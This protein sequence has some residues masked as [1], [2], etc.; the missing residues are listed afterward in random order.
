[1]LHIGEDFSKEYQLPSKAI[2]WSKQPVAGRDGTPEA[3]GYLYP[4][5]MVVQWLG[6]HLERQPYA[7]SQ[8]IVMLIPLAFSFLILI[9]TAILTPPDRDDVTERFFLKMRTKVR[10][11]GPEED[12][13][14]LE[15]AFR[16]PES[17]KKLLLFPNTQWEF[18]RW[19]KQDSLGVLFSFGVVFVVLGLLY[20]VVSV[21]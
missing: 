4:E 21:Y 3:R 17:T 14:D 6:F 18:Y 5:V 10:G 15:I 8:T 9:L 20:V 13:K 16:N 1:M 2:F 11:F 12:A 7:V 19:N